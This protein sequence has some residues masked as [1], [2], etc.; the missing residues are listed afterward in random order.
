MLR[1]LLT[2]LAKL[3]RHQTISVADSVL[4]SNSKKESIALPDLPMN[5]SDSWV[6]ALEED[7]Q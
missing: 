2:D 3:P 7:M 4:V 1:D 6:R 5:V